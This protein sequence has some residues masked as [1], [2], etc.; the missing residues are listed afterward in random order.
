MYQMREINKITKMYQMREINEMHSRAQSI[1]SV[2]D[3]RR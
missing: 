1:Q 3:D 2:L